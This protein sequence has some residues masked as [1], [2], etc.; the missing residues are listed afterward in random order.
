M[1]MT[2]EQFEKLKK[3]VID[4]I[5]PLA[6]ELAKHI[7][8]HNKIVWLDLNKFYE[9]LTKIDKEKYSKYIG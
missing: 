9:E 7:R 6:E 8:E 3:T 4:S 5:K 2:E 1:E